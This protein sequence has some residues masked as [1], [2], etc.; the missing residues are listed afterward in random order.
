LHG[1]ATAWRSRAAGDI[2]QHA[3]RSPHSTLPNLDG[4][5]ERELLQVKADVASAAARSHARTQV[6]PPLLDMFSQSEALVSSATSLVV[7]LPCFRRAYA[8]RVTRCCARQFKMRGC[9]ADVLQA[10]LQGECRIP[11]HYSF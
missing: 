9:Q 10:L 11:R 8:C 7:R 4:L 2:A 1:A 3:S 5:D 6:L